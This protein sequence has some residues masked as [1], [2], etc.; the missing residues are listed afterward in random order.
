M[1]VYWKDIRKTL[2]AYSEA[3]ARLSSD[4]QPTLPAYFTEAHSA[5]IKELDSYGLAN[6]WD[7]DRRER[8]FANRITKRAARRARKILSFRGKP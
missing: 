3:L 1:L 8:R 5:M 6:G 2:A 7:E 4:F